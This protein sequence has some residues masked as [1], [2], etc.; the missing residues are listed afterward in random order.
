MRTTERGGRAAHALVLGALLGLGRVSAGLAAD[1]APDTPETPM[2]VVFVHPER[3]ADVKDG[4]FASDTGKARILDDL[5]QCMRE[6]GQRYV[7]AG[8]SVEVRVTE[9]DLAGDFEPWRGSQFERVRVYRDIYS[10]R[11]DLEFLVTDGEGRLVREG[12]RSLRD[13]SY[14]QRAVLRPGDPLRFE[15]DMLRDWF[16]DE[17][18]VRAERL[19]P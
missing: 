11:I 17:F 2:S 1:P 13:L 7:P 8:F 18:A 15:K 6:A 9:V 10:P 16:R 3:F 19:A 14:L 5:G 4:V 12:R